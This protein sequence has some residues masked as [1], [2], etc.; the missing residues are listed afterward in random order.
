M[1]Q[2]NKKA[3]SVDIQIDKEPVKNELD[4]RQEAAAT[5]IKPESDYLEML[6]RLK[7][8]FD[9]YRKRTEKEKSDLAQYVR[10]NMIKSLLAILDDFE[11]LLETESD[12][13]K[14]KAGAHMFYK[15]FFSTLQ[16]FGLEAFSDQDKPFDPNIHEAVS[17][18]PVTEEKD[19]KIIETWQKG[20]RLNERL[21]RPA[22]V[23]VG[24]KKTGGWTIHE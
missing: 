7:A 21:L 2:D 22:Q 11:R 16:Q 17:V 5:E 23:Q 10:G 19:G 6:Q 13:A 15:K 24:Q 12:G 1:T 14:I 3:Y 9:N 4:Q 20:Y 18:L 8:D